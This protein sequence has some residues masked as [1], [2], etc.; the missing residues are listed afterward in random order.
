MKR[1]YLSIFFTFLLSISAFAT[2]KTQDTFFETDEIV[3]DKNTGVFTSVGY[4]D[5]DYNKNKLKTKTLE[6][7]TNTNEITA[8][9]SVN[10]DN[11]DG[12]MV[13]ENMVIN[14]KNE[15][16]SIGKTDISFGENSYAS[17]KSAEM[18][19]KDK[20]I[21]HDVE[22]TACKEGLS[23]CGDTPTWKIG[24]KT[25]K[26]DTNDGSLTYSNALMY[27]F[28]VP[29]FYLPYLVSYTP[30]IKNK[31]G[32][33]YP[34]FGTSSNL[35]SI[36]QTPF[37][38]KI[39]PYNDMTVT[40]MF[41]SDRGTLFITEYRTNQKDFQSVTN[42]SFK[43]K[44]G[45]EDKRWYLKTN[46]YFEINDIWRGIA[47]IERTSDDTYLRLYDFNSDPWLSSQIGIEGAYNR[48]YLTANTY[49]YQDLRNLTDSYTPKVLP[50]VDYRRVSEPNSYGGYWDLNLNTSHII[51][52]Y[53]N[54]GSKN[55]TNFRTSSIVKYTQPF[56]TSGGHLLDLTFSARGDLYVLDDIHNTNDSGETSYYSGTKSRGEV[57][58]DLMWKY[59][60][61]RSYANRT[62]I[63]QP[64]VQF[65]TS[66]KQSGDPEIPNMDSKY[67]ELE[68][69]NLFSSD[70]FSGYD[71]FESGTRVNYGLNFIQNYNNNQ[72][73]SLFIGQNYNIDVPDDIY[74]ENS[75]LKNDS[76]LS[77][78][79]ADIS[80]SPSS[81]FKLQYKTRMSNSNFRI[82]RN[83]VNLY[84][85][86]R[87]LNLTVN[88]VYLR[89]MFIEDDL[90]VRKDEINAY[91]SSQLTN[92]WRIF[93]GNRYDL[94]QNRDINIIGGV[95]YENDCFRFALNVINE[96]TRDRDYVGDKAVYF[97]LT[98]KTLGTISSSFGLGPTS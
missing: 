95:V 56:K 9:G 60:L 82:H 23:G 14:T 12:K 68:V 97:S 74:L 18:V 73:L 16:A 51:R 40:P 71:V 96:F 31:S 62:E 34:S 70:R 24:A 38:I 59:P 3:Y 33:L 91:L 43:A 69:E 93:A 67:M 61:Y 57:S 27:L 52:E 89:N 5:I 21:L 39:N 20:V 28:D 11:Q 63:L 66:N 80:Y 17:S 44:N 2:T 54:T 72:K 58:A 37:F 25:V 19:S 64:V 45:E 98:F 76:G 83:D 7:D 13:T 22:Y 50:I 53:N 46:N 48:S 77:D 78:I 36:V 10:I 84:I 4:S 35:G 81:F 75:G 94:Y 30:Q 1:L 55:E 49:F 32:F 15:N 92:N 47:N 42:A 6:F 29:I 90:P 41:T 85:G 79:V 26:H 87:A 86:P 8:K 65:I 88:Y